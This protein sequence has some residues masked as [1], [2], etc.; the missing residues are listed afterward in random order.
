MP[1]RGG[2][3]TGILLICEEAAVVLTVIAQFR[4]LPSGFSSESRA[5]VAAT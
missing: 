4:V 1:M 3:G 5:R 2:H